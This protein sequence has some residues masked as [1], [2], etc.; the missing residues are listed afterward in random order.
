MSKEKSFS[1]TEV[2]TLI[3]GFRND[4]TLVSERA[5]TLCEDRV[6]VKYRLTSLEGKVQSLGDV[7]RLSLPRITRLESKAGF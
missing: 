2:G 5:G 4:M 6:E 7:V 1:A 3:E